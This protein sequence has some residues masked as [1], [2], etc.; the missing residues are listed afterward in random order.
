MASVM[1]DVLETVSCE[2]LVVGI[3]CG[4][5]IERGWLFER[6]QKTVFFLDSPN[7]T[8]RHDGIVGEVI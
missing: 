1:G 6:M 2:L 3:D 7:S 5:V 4:L 8:R